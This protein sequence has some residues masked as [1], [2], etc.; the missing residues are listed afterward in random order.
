MITLSGSL[1]LLTNVCLAWTTH[2]IEQVLAQHPEM[3]Q[4]DKLSRI[5]PAHPESINF[6]GIFTFPVELY[7]D[8]LFAGGFAKDEIDR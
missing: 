1:R 7:R 6:R 3:V 5:S 4:P 8:R 2:Q